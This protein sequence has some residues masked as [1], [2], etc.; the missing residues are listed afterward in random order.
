MCH[1]PLIEGIRFLIL[2]MAADGRAHDCARGNPCA[3]DL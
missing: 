3:M 2:L 1:R